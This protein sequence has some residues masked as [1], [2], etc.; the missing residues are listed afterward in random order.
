MDYNADMRDFTAAFL[1]IGNEILSGRTTE[2]NLPVLAALLA[3]RGWQLGEARVVPDAA[4]EIAEALNALRRRHAIVFTSGGI[5]PTHDDITTET[6]AAALGE[7]MVE[8]PEALALL[9]KFYAARGLPFT[10]TRRRMARTPESAR[11]ILSEFPGAPAYRAENVIVCAGVPDI[12][13]LMAAAAA[14]TLPQGEQRTSSEL[15]VRCGESLFS[16]P[17]A[18]VAAAFPAVEIGSYP[19]QENG[20][21]VCQVA[22]TSADDAQRAAA[23]QMFC[24]IL[25]ADNLPFEPLA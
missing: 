24:D 9:E 19:R 15:R 6:V 5:G 20:D 25:A 10:E 22:F 13:R 14:E 8:H 18:K 2:K 21:Y 3:K 16:A 7:P 1:I 11:L 4:A 12:F 23:Q 17:L